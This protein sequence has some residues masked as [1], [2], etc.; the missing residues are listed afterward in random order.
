MT[1]F[2]PVTTRRL[3]TTVGCP[4]CEFE[5]QKTLSWLE[6]HFYTTCTA[7]GQNFGLERPLTHSTGTRGTVSG[8]LGRSLAN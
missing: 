2:R 7:C 3:T 4:S 5:M 6:R 8:E 1:L